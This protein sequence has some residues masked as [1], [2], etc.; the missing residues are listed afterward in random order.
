MTTS[1]PR[2]H[3]LPDRVARGIEGIGVQVYFVTVVVAIA[4]GVRGGGVRADARLVGIGEAV[5]VAIDD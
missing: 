4:V 2:S 1:L 3:S 5:I